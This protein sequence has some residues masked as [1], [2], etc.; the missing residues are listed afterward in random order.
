MILYFSMASKHT[1]LDFAFIY[2][3]NRDYFDHVG[4]IRFLTPLIATPSSAYLDVEFVLHSLICKFKDNL[5]K[6]LACC[7]W[8]GKTENKNKFHIRPWYKK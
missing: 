2:I 8:P 5:E 3:Q 4:V 6:A 7:W 1:I